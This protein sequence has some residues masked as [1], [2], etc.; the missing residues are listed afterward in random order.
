MPRARTGL[1]LQCSVWGRNST[2]HLK[3]SA[4]TLHLSPA[5]PANSTPPKLAIPQVMHSAQV[6]KQFQAL[7]TTWAKYL[8]NQACSPMLLLRGYI[9]RREDSRGSTQR[10]KTVAVESGKP[11]LRFKAPTL[12][13]TAST[14]SGSEIQDGLQP[15]TNGDLSGAPTRTSSPSPA[16]RPPPEPEPILKAA[17]AKAPSLQFF[18]FEKAI[19]DQLSQ[20]FLDLRVLYSEPLWRVVSKGK[21]NPGDISMTLKYLG[22][23]E[24][25]AALYIVIQ[26]EKVVSKKVKRFFAQ[27]HVLEDLR[28]DFQVHVIGVPLLRLSVQDDLSVFS[29]SAN[30]ASLIGVPLK[31]QATDGT[32]VEATLGGLIAAQT[33]DKLTIYG[34]TA[35]HH[36]G[37]LG[38]RDPSP[39]VSCPPDSSYSSDS[40]DDSD[41]SDTHEFIEIPRSEEQS[42]RNTDTPPL[43]IWGTQPIGSVYC[44]SL[45]LPENRD[46]ALVSIPPENWRPN[47]FLNRRVRMA[48][49]DSSDHPSSSVKAWVSTPRGL[50]GGTLRPKQSCLLVSPGKGFVNTLQF[51]PS[52][53]SC[54]FH[55]LSGLNSKLPVSP[56]LTAI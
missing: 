1:S 41:D 11:S 31:I 52:K 47:L 28:S 3:A 50:Q 15:E 39:P 10:L 29:D 40:S 55:V 35:S 4:A 33:G 51:I 2:P 5:F 9:K 24:T 53:T 17:M 18:V 38:S 22:E 12:S 56:K 32:S 37:I 19:P 23:D 46:W 34:I 27:A 49:P 48:P 43:T 14:E 25:H 45:Q 44:H 54:K 7:I 42:H 26:C 8:T 16:P 13:T 36:L 6:L 30:H 21:P 20:R